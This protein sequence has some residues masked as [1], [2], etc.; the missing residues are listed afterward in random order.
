MSYISQ[1][2]D[3]HLVGT[4]FLL[5]LFQ[6]EMQEQLLEPLNLKYI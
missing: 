3:W 6:V 1:E 4:L 2:S 5:F